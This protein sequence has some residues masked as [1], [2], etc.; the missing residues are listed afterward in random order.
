MTP[1][2]LGNTM[3]VMIRD[4]FYPDD[5]KGFYQ[6]R[7]LLLQAVTYP[8]QWF[9]TRGVKV[10]ES[11]YREILMEVI[12]TIKRYGNT[13]KIQRFSA[14][15]LHAIQTHMRF[16][17]DQ[18]YEEGKRT[19][20]AVEEVMLGLRKKA[21]PASDETVPV[22]AE[23]HRTLRP[24]KQGRKKNSAKAAADQPDLFA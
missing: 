12:Q 18:Y 10:T 13:A 9:E 8:A 19:R 21:A 22:L 4:Q 23:L 15:L 7:T 2:E 24:Y 6:E 11:R 3:L 5:H 14:Y 1:S 20:Q 16:H 17:G